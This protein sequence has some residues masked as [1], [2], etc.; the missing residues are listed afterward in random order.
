VKE[1]LQTDHKALESD[2]SNKSIITIFI[3][4]IIIIIAVS[5]VTVVNLFYDHRFLPIELI[6]FP[7][8]F[9]GRIF[10]TM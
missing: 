10:R 2:R 6:F 5:N 4:I 3:I 9:E 1:G 7:T 8:I